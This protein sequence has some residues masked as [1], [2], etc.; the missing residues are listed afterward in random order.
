MA[1]KRK[2]PPEELEEAIMKYLMEKDRYAPLTP[3]KY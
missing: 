1:H 2:I 3:L